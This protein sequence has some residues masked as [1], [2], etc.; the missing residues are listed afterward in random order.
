M[1]GALPT[2]IWNH[3]AGAADHVQL[4]RGV[5][6]EAIRARVEVPWGDRAA[7]SRSSGPLPSVDTSEPGGCCARCSS[8]WGSPRQGGRP[9]LSSAVEFSL[10]IRA[11]I[12]RAWSGKSASWRPSTAPSTVRGRPLSDDPVSA[13]TL[14]GAARNLLELRRVL[15]RPANQA[16]SSVRARDLVDPVLLRRVERGHSDIPWQY[17]GFVRGLVGFPRHRSSTL[18]CPRSQD[19]T[20]RLSTTVGATRRGGLLPTAQHPAPACSKRSPNV[21]ISSRSQP[22]LPAVLRDMPSSAPK[23]RSCVDHPVG[24]PSRVVGPSGESDVV[25]HLV[26]VLTQ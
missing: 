17:T 12:E 13:R 21:A 22:L 1:L 5:L 4:R 7:F 15:F 3:D 9:C 14:C 26:C 2:K 6:P 10:G 23:G 16:R 20:A 19:P 24:R 25:I 18:E 8:R 11:W